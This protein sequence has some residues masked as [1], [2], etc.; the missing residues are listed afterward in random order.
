[1]VSIIVPVYNVEEY[2]DECIGSI[3]NQT[4]KD[5]EI[6]LINDGS[7]DHS[8]EICYLWAKKDNRIRVITKKNEG[9]AVC[10]NIGLREA[11]GEY[12]VFVDSDDWIYENMVELLLNAILDTGASIAVCDADVELPGGKISDFS[13]QDLEKK[14]VRITQEPEFIVSVKYTMWGKLYRKDF[15][16]YNRIEQPDIKFE[17]FA[18]IP[19]IFALSDKVACV[20]ERLYF[21]RYRQ[22]STIHNINFIDDRFKAIDYLL[23]SFK[24]RG[25]F[26]EWKD[27]LQRI[28][29]ERAVVIM[30]QIY[31]ILTKYYKVCY[32]RYEDILQKNFNINLLTINPHFS[33]YCRTGRIDTNIFGRYNICVIGSYNLMIVAKMM[34]Q[35]GTPEFLNN[36]YSFSNII[37]MMSNG[38]KE[39]CGLN[40]SHKSEYRQK[41]LIQDFTKCLKN[42]NKCEFHDIDY[43]LI[44][45]LEERFDTG[46]IDESYFTISDAFLEISDQLG[47]SYEVLDMNSSKT[48]ELWRESCDKFIKL[49]EVYVQ[50]KSIILVKNYLS[51]NILDENGKLTPFENIDEIRM[52]NQILEKKYNYFSEHM[53]GVLVWETKDNA[54]Y[55]T[56]KFFKHG[57]YPWHLNNKEYCAISQCMM[58]L[59]RFRYRES[60]EQQG[61]DYAV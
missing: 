12:V 33:T 19:I 50:T 25:I 46:K 54:F 7:T 44:D 52:Q 5:L 14:C 61:D 21:Y 15:L 10:R 40:L 59:L 11:K 3:V 1:M 22:S 36:H 38:Y 35:V 34:M 37:S 51:E 28:I 39:A 30:R 42:K 48:W 49:L 45:F 55:Y 6:L 56:D 27:I 2:L 47:I 18:V 43:V 41:H 57:C 17:D 8:G 9:Q 29:T 16:L 24:E 20:N 58:T 26:E 23:T 13:L 53:Q 31:P 32:E 60:D 4:C